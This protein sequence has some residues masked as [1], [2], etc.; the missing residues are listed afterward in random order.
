MSFL[1]GV[2]ASAMKRGSVPWYERGEVAAL[3]AFDLSLGIGSGFTSANGLVVDSIIDQ[4]GGGANVLPTSAKA[5]VGTFAGLPSA[6]FDGGTTMRNYQGNCAATAGIM[7]D[8]DGR[9][10]SMHHVCELTSV[11][12]ASQYQ[13]GLTSQAGGINPGTWVVHNTSINHNGAIFKSPGTNTAIQGGSYTAVAGQKMLHSIQYDGVA[14]TSTCIINGEFTRLQQAN[15]SANGNIPMTTLNRVTVAGLP[16][17]GSGIPTGAWAG[18][19]IYQNQTVEDIAAV[20]RG[21]LERWAPELEDATVLVIGYGQS[22]AGGSDPATNHDPVAFVDGTAYG[23]VLSD[24]ILRK[25]SVGHATFGAGSKCA[26]AIWFAEELGRILGAK[27]IV[28]NSASGGVGLV[29]G[30]PNG[31][32]GYLEPET[33]AGISAGATSSYKTNTPAFVR[34]GQLA[35]LTPKFSRAQYRVLLFVGCET[36]QLNGQPQ[37]EIERALNATFDAFRADLGITHF[38]IS[39]LGMRGNTLVLAQGNEASCEL[40]RQAQ[41]NVAAQRSD[42]F[43][44]YDHL[45]EFNSVAF[46]VNDLVVDADGAWVS[47]IGYLADGLHYT[48]I[49]YKAVGVTG[50]RNFATALGIP[51]P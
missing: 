10:F 18:G 47:G 26:P 43:I 13:I 19:A 23:F 41:R 38:A 29:G 39:E 17:V 46:S 16:S 2:I 35:R 22:N 5:A 7:I 36:D 12:P 34:L 28:A 33:A 32:A 25:T 11:A 45:K 15:S 20:H 40:V 3:V 51:I 24:S 21:M 9:I 37:S 49:Q 44:V 42:T 1:A 50:A 30:G 31:A 48:S 4:T 27:P 14:L 8:N 6:I